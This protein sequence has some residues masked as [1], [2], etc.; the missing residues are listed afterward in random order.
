MKR[1]NMKNPQKNHVVKRRKKIKQ[2]NL[3]GNLLMM[4]R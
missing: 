2:E 3:K 1:K 4:K